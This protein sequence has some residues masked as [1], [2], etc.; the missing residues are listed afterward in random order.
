MRTIK[1]VYPMVLDIGCFCHTIDRVGERF[2]V[3][4]LNEF[5]TYW[6]SL[7]SHSNKACLVWKEQTG[8]AFRGY[9]P[10]RWWSKWEVEKQLLVSHYPKSSIL[11]KFS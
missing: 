9:C 2:K 7:F 10:T 1:V 4:H 11:L 8:Q 3:P 5:S 6:V